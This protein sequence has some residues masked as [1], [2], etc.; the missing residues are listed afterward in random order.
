MTELKTLKDLHGLMLINKDLE[1]WESYK[2][3]GREDY[4]YIDVK[5]LKTEAIKW[6]KELKKEWIDSNDTN[7]VYNNP[8]LKELEITE[9][10]DGVTITAETFIKHFFN[11]TEEDLK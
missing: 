10:E 9:F 5:T 3:I 4:D 7:A 8:K 2:Y 1:C 11:L 6:I